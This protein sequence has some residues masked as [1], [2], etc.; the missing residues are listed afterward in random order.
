MKILA[1]IIYW[2]GVGLAVLAGLGMLAAALFIFSEVTFG[3]FVFF[4]SA[5]LAAIV[6]VFLIGLWHW[7]REKRRAE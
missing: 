5:V 7:A 3:D 6:G 4:G 2:T 1:N